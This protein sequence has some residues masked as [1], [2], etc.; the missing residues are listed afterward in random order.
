MQGMF[1]A[2]GGCGYVKK[3]NFL[4]DENKVFDPRKTLTVQKIL[5]VCGFRSAGST[6]FP[7]FS[8]VLFFSKNSFGHDLHYLIGTK[9]VKVFMG[10]G[11]YSDFHHTHF[12]RF[13][14]PDFFVRVR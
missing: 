1:R 13:S 2:N 12:D 8:F 9:Q 10:E 14:P 7:S 5:R 11:W 3:P 4:M 6:C